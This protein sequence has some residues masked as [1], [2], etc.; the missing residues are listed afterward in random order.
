MDEKN[1]QVF[2]VVVFS[3]TRPCWVWGVITLEDLSLAVV[4]KIAHESWYMI[5]S[6]FLLKLPEVQVAVTTVKKIAQDEQFL[7]FSIFW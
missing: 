1:L 2:W 7:F 5:S 6:L 4:T 3:C